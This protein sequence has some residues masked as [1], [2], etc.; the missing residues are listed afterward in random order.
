MKKGAKI[1]SQK[2]VFERFFVLDVVEAEPHSLR[3]DG[4][5]ARIERE[6]LRHED[7]VAAVLLYNP[8]TD[9]IL[10]NR[11]FRMGVFLR[12]EDDPFVLESA[13]GGVDKGETPEE[14]ARRE[15]L[16]ETGCTVRELEF[17][18]TCYPS[19]GCLDQKFYMY[20]GCIDEATPG[21]H[22]V[23]EEGEEIQTLLVPAEE[24]I[25]MLDRNEI[26]NATT[27]LMLHWFARHHA[28]LKKKWEKA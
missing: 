2:R 22:G 20:A 7:A 28:R 26:Q 19:G 15:A 12:G 18:G 16:E 25:R 5:T 24:A 21:F 11:Q 6:V 13:A 14:G 10:F 23:E 4:Y 8:R 9:E 27:V 17:I 3:H 1:I